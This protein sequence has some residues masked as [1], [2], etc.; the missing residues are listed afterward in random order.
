MLEIWSLFSNQLVNLTYYFFSSL[1]LP[2]FQPGEFEK[3]TGNK[4]TDFQVICEIGRGSYGGVYRV[5][6][7]VTNNEYAMKKINMKHVKLKHQKEALKEVQIL[8]KV[9]NPYIIRYY[10]SFVEDEFLYII[11]ELAEGGDLAAV[12][13]IKK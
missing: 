5:L 9:R 3:E 8:K 6:S 2:S 1:I 4:L 11:M 12:R 10:T 13:A 7:L